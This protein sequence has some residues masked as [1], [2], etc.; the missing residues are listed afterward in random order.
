LSR[1][2]VRLEGHYEVNDLSYGRDYVWVPAHALVEC[3]CGQIMDADAQHTTCPNCRRAGWRRC[4]RRST[5]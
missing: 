2:K 4:L 1:V 5:R 3:E